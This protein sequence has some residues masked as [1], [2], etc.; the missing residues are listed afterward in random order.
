[1]A[2]IKTIQIIDFLMVVIS[3]PRSKSTCLVAPK[4]DFSFGEVS[5]DMLV[6]CSVLQLDDKEVGEKHG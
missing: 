2:K 4:P 5:L 3:S 1:M 6:T